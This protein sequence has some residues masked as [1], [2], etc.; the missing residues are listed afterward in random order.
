M[1][2]LLLA[3]CILMMGCGGTTVTSRDVR[4]RAKGITIGHNTGNIVETIATYIV[5]CDSAHRAG[6]TIEINPY[7]YRLLERVK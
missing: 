1:K 6:D 4:F 3:L 5:S 7:T 2:L